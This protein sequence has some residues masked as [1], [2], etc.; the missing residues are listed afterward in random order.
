MKDH[1]TARLV[2]ELTDIAKKF[3]SHGCLREKISRAVTSAH[4]SDSILNLPIH[5]IP[6]SSACREAFENNSITTVQELTALTVVEALK[7]NGVG[8]RAVTEAMDALA[9]VGLSLGMKNIG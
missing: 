1:E 9:S 5:A 4:K 7:L 6:I 2:N 3:H 8:K